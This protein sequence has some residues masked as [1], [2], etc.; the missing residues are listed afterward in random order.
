MQF[1]A[2]VEPFWKGFLSRKDK[3][4]VFEQRREKKR[5]Q[6]VVDTVN[7]AFQAEG[8]P[9]QKWDTETGEPVCHIRIDKLGVF[10]DLRRYAASL[11]NKEAENVMQDWT[12]D[13][14][15]PHLLRHRERKSYYIPVGFAHPIK[16]EEEEKGNWTLVGSVLSLAAELGEI[17]RNLK[18]QDSF[19]IKKMVDFLQV[20]EKDIT[21]FESRTYEPEKF[22]LNF[23][24]LV[25]QKLVRKA[26]EH[27]LP[28]IFA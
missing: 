6:K 22:W 24:F 15:F 16:I 28:I 2:R 13:T 7:A 9:Q 18:V 1:D 12:V 10:Q 14:S 20:T 26:W 4:G 25:I 5:L 17:N 11:E 23:G 19:Q 3:M 27:E 8:L 21:K